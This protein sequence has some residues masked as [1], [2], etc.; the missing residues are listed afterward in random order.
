MACAVSAGRR[1]RSAI[2]RAPVCHRAAASDCASSA[3]DSVVR[4]RSRLRSVRV[5]VCSF[6]TVSSVGDLMACVVSAGRRARPA[7]CCA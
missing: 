4:H 7:T 1:A 5:C 6:V 3:P 2:R